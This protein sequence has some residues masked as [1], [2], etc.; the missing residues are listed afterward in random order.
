MKSSLHFK[1]NTTTLW[2]PCRLR[3]GSVRLRQ[4][5]SGSVSLRQSP[6][7]R[8]QQYFSCCEA[9]SDF[10]VDFRHKPLQSSLWRSDKYEDLSKCRRVGILNAPLA[11]GGVFPHTNSVPAGL[12]RN[13]TQVPG[14]LFLR[15]NPLPWRWVGCFRTLTPSLLDLCEIPTQVPGILFPRRNALP[16][17]LVGCFRTLPPPLVDWGSV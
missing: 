9:E 17:R 10:V 5:P 12:M 1:K 7:G 3:P 15:R 13:S 4:A 6:S 8:R 14:T 2:A 11:V 16:W